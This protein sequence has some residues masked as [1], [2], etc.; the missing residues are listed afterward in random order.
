[1]GESSAPRREHVTL[2]DGRKLAWRRYPGTGAPLVALHGLFDCSLGWKQTASA[3]PGG[4]WAPDLPGF[5]GSDLPLEARLDAYARDIAEALSILGVRQFA[6]VGHSL[7]GA[8]ASFLADRFPERV[9][10]LALIAPAGYQR[11]PL[12]DVLNAGLL[13]GLA[14][15]AMPFAL[16]NRLTAAGIYMLLISGGQRP[17]PEQLARLTE[18]AHSVIPGAMMANQA[19]IKA[20]HDPGSATRRQLRYHGPAHIFWGECDRLVPISHLPAVQAALPQ[21]STTIRSG[22]AHHPQLQAP[23]ELAAWLQ[24]SCCRTKLPPAALLAAA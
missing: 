5:G 10:T 13:R 11:I 17:D 4:M 24:D 2:S 18:S 9:R 22:L 6:L 16:G 19:L 12:S 21:A 7:G 3:M 8:V 1:M 23:T 15:R 20:T 14:R